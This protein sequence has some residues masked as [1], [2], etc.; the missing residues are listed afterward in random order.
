[1]AHRAA[2]VG[3]ELIGVM[4]LIETAAE[5]DFG[6]DEM[7]LAGAIG[8]QAAVALDNARLHRRQEERNRWL[9]TLVEA[10]RVVASTLDV[11]ELLASVA[12]LAAESVL[13]EA[14]FIYEYDGE[15]DVIITRASCRGRGRGPRRPYRQRVQS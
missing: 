6:A 12:R 5:R 10:G 15:R 3:G 11:D 1:M 7:R 8:E 2:R 9:G 4:I 14:A 13:A